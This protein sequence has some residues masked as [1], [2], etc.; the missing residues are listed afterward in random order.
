M[1]ALYSAYEGAQVA[2]NTPVDQIM[3]NVVRGI[4]KFD[5][6]WLSFLNGRDV[7]VVDV[8]E[9]KRLLQEKDKRAVVITIS[10]FYLAMALIFTAVVFVVAR[11]CD[12]YFDEPGRRA[13]RPE[14]Q[15]YEHAKSSGT[16]KYSST[17][18]LTNVTEDQF[19]RAKE[20]ARKTIERQRRRN[21]R[22]RLLERFGADESENIEHDYTISHREILECSSEEGS[23]M[24]NGYTDLEERKDGFD[25]DDYEVVE[26][27][28]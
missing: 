2:F 3:K 11:F 27:E 13:Q 9:L 6:I 1:N 14:E 15:E 21:M 8:E 22:K 17:L 4:L 12:Y 7:V 23:E 24:G 19:D 18:P 10:S 25:S 20:V 16:D 26:A 5:A 28:N